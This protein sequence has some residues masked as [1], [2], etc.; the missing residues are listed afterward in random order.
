MKTL[1]FATLAFAMAAVQ[2]LFAAQPI[3]LGITEELIGNGGFETGT[4]SSWSLS[5]PTGFSNVGSDSIFAH[6]GTHYANLNTVGALGSLSQTFATT[7]GA[8]YDVSFWLA[9]D[10][11]I[12]PN[13]V[14]TVF[15]GGVPLL[16]LNNAGTF[17]YNNFTFTNLQATG[18]TTTLEFRFRDND[19]FFRLDDVSVVPEPSTTALLAAA[20]VLTFATLRRSKARSAC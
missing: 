1:A 10:V 8:F 11:T 2:S 15:F 7:P 6:S 4:F 12:A 5:D 17:G 20:A 19:D 18:T 13:N 9:H 3:S 14:F 16:N